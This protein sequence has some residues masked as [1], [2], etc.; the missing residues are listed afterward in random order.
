MFSLHEDANTNGKPRASMIKAHRPQLQTTHVLLLARTTRTEE[1]RWQPSPSAARCA[2]Q[3]QNRPNHPTR[4]Q[5]G[6]VRSLGKANDFDPHEAHPA[7]SRVANP[8]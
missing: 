5:H 1:I 6:S 2:R 8:L 3:R 7:S 4:R